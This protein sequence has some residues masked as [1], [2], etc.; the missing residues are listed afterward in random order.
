MGLKRE[1]EKH[2]IQLVGRW[3]WIWEELGKAG[4]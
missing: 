2:E 4:E 3:G 1:R